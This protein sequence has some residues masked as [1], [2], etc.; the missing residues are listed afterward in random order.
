MTFHYIKISYSNLVLTKF[1]IL[2]YKSYVFVMPYK[3]TRPE[4][5]TGTKLLKFLT[6]YS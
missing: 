4:S 5:V 3:M 2:N 6:Q 1:E